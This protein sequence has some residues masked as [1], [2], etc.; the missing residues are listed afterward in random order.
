[1]KQIKIPFL[2]N[3]IPLIV[4][5]MGALI[6]F[7]GIIFVLKYSKQ[8]TLLGN[9]NSI[10]QSQD[11]MDSDNDGLRDWEE[12]LYHT[13][14]LNPDT[15]GD[16]YLDGEEVNSGHNPLVKAPGDKLSF[17]PLPLGKQYNVTEK[18]FNDEALHEL[19]TSYLSQKAEYLQNH[20]EI[21][22]P[23]EFLDF[24]KDSTIEEIVKRSLSQSYASLIGENSENVSE[25]PE[26]FDIKISDEQ[27]KI[28]EDNS[29]EAIKLYLSKVTDWLNSDIFFFQ[30][31]SL[32][33]V[34]EALQNND[35]S[36]IDKLIQVNDSW[37]NTTKEITVPSSWKEIHKEGLRII[38]LTRN[39]FISIRDIKNDPLKAY[40]A[41]Y[42]LD[43]IT[44]DWNNLMQN[45]VD[46][47]EEQEIVLSL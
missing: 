37:I 28:S 19:F 38:I 44:N 33:A 25:I 12:E 32:Q 2:N 22:N 7:G 26:I 47:T 1:M 23:Q 41:V 3:K 10:N 4:I 35:F 29:K 24:T 9:K 18:I 13:D 40:Y 21:T 43:P 5:V 14:P 17:Y 31:K 45:A 27:I 42:E 20:P 30:E 46:L 16:G 11:F 6:V 36:K 34:T 15:D 8:D 39:I